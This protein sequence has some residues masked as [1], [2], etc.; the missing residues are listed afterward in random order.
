MLKHRK[1]NHE[2]QEKHYKS[3]LLWHDEF[4]QVQKVMSMLYGAANTQSQPKI[5]ELSR[6]YR[7]MWLNTASLTSFKSFVELLSPKTPPTYKNLFLGLSKQPGWGPKTSAL[8]VKSIYH[9]H[10]DSYDSRLRIWDD[11]PEDITYLDKLYL[12]VD[13]VI[14]EIFNHLGDRSWTFKSI[15]DFIHEHYV[16]DEIEVWDDLWFWGFITQKVANKQRIFE[17]NA[18]KYWALECSN[19]S[20]VVESEIKKLSLEFLSLMK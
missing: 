7:F 16:G 19:K 2:L 15:N 8:F 6:F 20:L 5:D 4:D 18:N 12:P 13:R 9:I 3:A 17:W 1:F 14:M 10:H 11:S